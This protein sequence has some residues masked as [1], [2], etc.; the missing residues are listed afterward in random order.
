MK[1]IIIGIAGGTGSGKT[2]IVDIIQQQIGEKITLLKQDSYYKDFSHLSAA[3]RD[4]I[5]FDHP[6][7]FDTKLFIEHINSLKSNI[8]VQAPTYDY[9][10]HTR[11]KKTIKKVPNKI[12][13]VEG[14]LIFEN[15]KVRN[16]LDI[17][18][19]VD[20]DADLR[21]L[22]RITRDIKERGRNL[23]SIVNQ[24]YETVRPM[25][26]KFVEPSKR[27]A[28]VIVPEGGENKIA[29]NMILSQIQNILKF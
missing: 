29:I 23:T 27:F 2:T 15:A 16:L 13:I 21:I 22:R 25:H 1:P 12:I 8:F 3:K 11:T 5:N 6:S 17:K 14:I 26:I 18:I 24:Y 28:D 4:K 10:T 19:Y 7:A 9:I 20:T